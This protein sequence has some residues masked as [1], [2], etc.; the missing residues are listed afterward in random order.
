[1]GYQRITALVRHAGRHTREE[2]EGFHQKVS[3]SNPQSCGH[4]WKQCSDT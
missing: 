1:M 4:S 3:S 2:S